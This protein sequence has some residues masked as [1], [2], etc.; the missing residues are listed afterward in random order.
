MAYKEMFYVQVF[1]I[2]RKNQLVGGRSYACDDAEHADRKARLLSEKV[3]GVVAF[4]QM[5]DEN[6][7]DAEE[8]TLIAFHGRVPSEVKEA[9]AA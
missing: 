9:R 6:A 3:A 7:G 4:S 5:V 8:P 2:N 1:E